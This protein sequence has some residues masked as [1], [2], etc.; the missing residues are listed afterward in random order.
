M[1]E[2]GSVA[3]AEEGIEIVDDAAEGGSILQEAGTGSS[4][5]MQIA[6]ENI[7]EGDLLESRTLATQE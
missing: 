3:K 7:E 1:G 4:L 6:C 2:V 5:G